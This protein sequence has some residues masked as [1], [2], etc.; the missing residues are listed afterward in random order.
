MVLFRSWI[1][2]IGLGWMIVRVFGRRGVP[3]ALLASR[4]KKGH[5]QKTAIGGPRG[6]GQLCVF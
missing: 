4:R 5:Q 6:S 3:S 2:G 1:E